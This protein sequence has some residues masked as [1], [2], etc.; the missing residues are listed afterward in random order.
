[1]GV[2]DG[3]GRQGGTDTRAR[4][5]DGDAGAGNGRRVQ[6]ICEHEERQ[7]AAADAD[8]R[9]DDQVQLQG[10]RRGQREALLPPLGRHGRRS[11]AA[12]G[13]MKRSLILAL[14]LL[15]VVAAPLG[16]QDTPGV[17]ADDANSR[18]GWTITPSLGAAYMY[19][20]NISLFTDSNG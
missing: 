15:T 3:R 1:A 12:R 16:A 5:D 13:L 8:G 14:G 4:T 18:A 2:R 20:D 10:S 9:A 6:G 11:L 19:D 17:G 7:G